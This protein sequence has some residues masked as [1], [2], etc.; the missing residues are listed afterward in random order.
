M[1]KR[2]HYKW[3]LK[4]KKK[5]LITEIILNTYQVRDITLN[6]WRSLCIRKAA[7]GTLLLVAEDSNIAAICNMLFPSLSFAANN[8]LFAVIE[9]S[10]LNLYMKLNTFFWRCRMAIIIMLR[11]VDFSRHNIEKSGHASS[12]SLTNSTIPLLTAM[13]TA[14][15][16]RPFSSRW[17]LTVGN[18]RHMWRRTSLDC[19]WSDF[20]SY[21]WFNPESINN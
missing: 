4:K 12:I 7:P 2:Y 3:K 15:K 13:Q 14:S 19:L 21:I 10:A 9:C 1:I 18:T 16:T 8:E 20:D 6:H 11:C 5:I 17:A